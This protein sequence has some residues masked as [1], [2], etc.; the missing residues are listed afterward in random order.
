MTLG[1]GITT[2]VRYKIVG[3]TRLLLSLTYV[4]IC[5]DADV[6]PL[7]VDIVSGITGPRGATNFNFLLYPKFKCGVW[8]DIPYT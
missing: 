4:G 5:L 1:G 7:Y 8:G 6:S 2:L 3:I